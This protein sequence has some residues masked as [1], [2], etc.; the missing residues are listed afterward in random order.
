ME[1]RREEKISSVREW[2]GEKN[3]KKCSAVTRVAHLLSML[4]TCEN[5]FS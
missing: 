1:P 5:L 4:L 2:R 3:M